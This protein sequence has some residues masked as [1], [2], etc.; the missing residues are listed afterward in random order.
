MKVTIYL[1]SSYCDEHQ[2]NGL[3]KKIN[4]LGGLFILLDFEMQMLDS[5]VEAD[6]CE[7]TVV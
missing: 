6:E 1:F 2:C 3:L 5:E 7:L 4:I